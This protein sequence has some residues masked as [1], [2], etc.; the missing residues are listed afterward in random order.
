MMVARKGSR[1]GREGGGGQRRAPANGFRPWGDR[2]R[3]EIHHRQAGSDERESL[4][5]KAQAKEAASGLCQIWIRMGCRAIVDRALIVT[6]PLPLGQ[7]SP[8]YYSRAFTPFFFRLV[9]VPFS[10]RP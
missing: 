1:P 10:A 3:V 8:P 4:V 2:D 9:P 7:P 5:L 6:R